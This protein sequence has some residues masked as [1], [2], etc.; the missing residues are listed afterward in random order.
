MSDTTFVSSSGHF[1]FRLLV[2]APEFLALLQKRLLTCVKY[3]LKFM[4]DTS[5]IQ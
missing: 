1:G 4:F 2:V 3:T 5:V